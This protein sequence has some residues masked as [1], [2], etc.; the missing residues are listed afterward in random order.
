MGHLYLGFVFVFNENVQN[1]SNITLCI[2][3]ALY[4]SHLFLCMYIY[5]QSPA[6]WLPVHRGPT[7]GNVWE[8]FTY[9]YLQITHRLFI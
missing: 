5:R 4:V 3:S 8:A 1:T 2:V 6:G 7:L 9:L